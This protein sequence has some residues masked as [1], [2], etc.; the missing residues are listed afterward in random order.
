MKMNRSLSLLLA[1]CML[2][3]LLS[4]CG[5]V[6]S[7]LHR[8]AD[9]DVPDADPVSVESHAYVPI[10][11]DTISHVQT[12]SSTAGH[13]YTDA[14]TGYLRD[15][16][17]DGQSELFLTCPA[18]D[19]DDPAGDGALLRLLFYA[20]RD[21]RAVPLLS[22]DSAVPMNQDTEIRIELVQREQEIYVLIYIA[23]LDHDENPDLPPIMRSCVYNYYRMEDGALVQEYELKEAEAAHIADPFDINNAYNRTL[24]GEAIS[25]AEA[26]ALWEQF[27]PLEMIYRY[28]SDAA[29]E[30]AAVPLDTLLDRLEGEPEATP[31]PTPTPESKEP[32][33]ASFLGKPFSEVLAQFGEPDETVEYEGGI[34]RS[35]TDAG[36]AF[37]Y[38]WN[39]AEEPDPIV[40]TIYI[41]NT[42]HPVYRTITADKPYP[43]LASAFS[44]EGIMVAVPEFF[45]N[46]LDDLD[47][48]YTEIALPDRPGCGIS[49]MW[50][51]DPNSTAPDEVRLHYSPN[52]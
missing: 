5:V 35:Y 23:Y 29:S 4:G 17:N 12:Y 20:I 8:G 44:E 39:T 11:E 19:P 50:L 48:Y 41:S 1:L 18:E 16:D 37:G 21:D 6:R 47:D 34:F 24:N 27:T 9:D 38:P 22:E 43:E 2:L 36:L 31:A 32:D 7:L 14:G 42:K 10:V 45:H 40:T 30:Y 33:I 51:T 28:G 25:E 52:A 15:I 46:E 3:A 13:R 49:F 26:N